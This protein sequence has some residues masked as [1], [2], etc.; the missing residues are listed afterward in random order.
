MSSFGPFYVI[1]KILNP[2][3]LQYFV[4]IENQILWK[5][6]CMIFWSELKD[7][8]Q[9]GLYVIEK[10]YRV[11][12]FAFVCDAPARAFLKCILK[13]TLLIIVVKDV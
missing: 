12:I 11:S 2:L 4:V 9:N 10:W 8:M 3:L 7:L 6:T 13:D 1:Y 5:N